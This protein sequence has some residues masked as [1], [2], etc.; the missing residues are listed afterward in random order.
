MRRR[1]SWA[2]VLTLLLVASASP[3]IHAEEAQKPFVFIGRLLAVRE[4]PEE[5]EKD[6]WNFDSGY[7]L[8][9]E[10][11]Q[12][13]SGRSQ[14]NPVTF[15]FYG[16]YGLDPFAFYPHALLFVYEEDGLNVMARYLAYPVARTINGL[17]AYCGDPYLKGAPESA[18]KFRKVEFGER[19]DYSP[20]TRE[21]HE[22]S[23]DMHMGEMRR[24]ILDCRKAVYADDLADYAIGQAEPG[25]NRI[26][27]FEK[28]KAP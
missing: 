11:L 13:V 23:A 22:N 2:V 6:C 20:L 25:Y 4:L 3:S 17:W 28:A 27:R 14:N 16:H 9:Y 7:E 24:G 10:V 18:K 26:W 8:K 12:E 5:C 21:H 15:R 19:I 1:F